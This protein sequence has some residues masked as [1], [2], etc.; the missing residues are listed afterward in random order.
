MFLTKE[1]KSSTNEI[2][3]RPWR[4]RV[5]FFGDFRLFYP[6]WLHALLNGQAYWATSQPPPFYLPTKS[7]GNWA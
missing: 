7:G 6:S 4:N 1:K 5:V 2:F 3:V